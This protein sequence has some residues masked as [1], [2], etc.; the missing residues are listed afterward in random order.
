MWWTRLQNRQI[1]CYENMDLAHWNGH[2][3]VPGW[4]FWQPDPDAVDHC[5]S[6]DKAGGDAPVRYRASEEFPGGLAA[7]LF[8]QCGVVLLAFCALVSKVIDADLFFAV[9][10]RAALG[11]GRRR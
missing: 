10:G 2:C 9:G 3:P 4:F 8:H 7:G 5:R 1:S 11:L 6:W